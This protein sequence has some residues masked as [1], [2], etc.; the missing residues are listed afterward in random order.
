MTD[1]PL[2]P[3]PLD[4][5]VLAFGHWQEA[6]NDAHAALTAAARTHDWAQVETARATVDHT[7]RNIGTALN[8]CRHRLDPQPIPRPTPDI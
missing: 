4:V 8:I 2:P 6:L 5:L 3:L 7:A 1:T